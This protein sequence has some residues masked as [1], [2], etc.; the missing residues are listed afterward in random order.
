MEPRVAGRG[1]NE[2]GKRQLHAQKARRG[3]DRARFDESA[4]N[5]SGPVE[6]LPVPAQR[7]LPVHAVGHV[8]VGLPRDL[9]E[10]DGLEVEGVEQLAQRRN[11]AMIVERILLA[12]EQRRTGEK[13]GQPAECGAAAHYVYTSRTCQEALQSETNQQMYNTPC[14]YSKRVTALRSR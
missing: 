2:Y 1:R 9:R 14:L 7:E 4:G 10:R 11:A 13:P 8:V 6:R 12:G 3:L 5:Q